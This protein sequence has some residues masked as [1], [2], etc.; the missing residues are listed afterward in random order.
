MPRLRNNTST[1]VG[2]AVDIVL[3]PPQGQL[4]AV[5]SNQKRGKKAGA[6]SRSAPP[7]VPSAPAA[8]PARHAFAVPVPDNQAALLAQGKQTLTRWER[9]APAGEG[10]ARQ[11]AA[12][13]I[14]HAFQREQKTLAL[15]NL[16]L[17][18]LPDCLDKL[19]CIE[20]LNL[21]NNVLSV[22][23]AL[24]EEL[25]R[26]F[27]NRNRLRHFP[28]KLPPGL[29]ELWLSRNGMAQL[30]KD[31]P[32]TIATLSIEENP[33]TTLPSLP[34]GLKRL[35]ARTTHLAALPP[36]P[37][38]LI[39]LDAGDTRLAQLP[40]RLPDGLLKIAVDENNLAELPV[41]PRS[42]QKLQVSGNLLQVLP[43][44]PRG[45][46]ELSAGRN[47]LIQLPTL[48]RSLQLLK[49][50]T[51]LL[52]SLPTL[53]PVV[54]AIVAHNNLIE[55]VPALPSLLRELDL[56]FNPLR[57]IPE[58]IVERLNVGVNCIAALR[59]WKTFGSARLSLPMLPNRW[60][61]RAA[62]EGS[63]TFAETDKNAAAFNIFQAR[64]I[65]TAEYKN[66]TTRP[67]LATRM[68]RLVA[69]M[70]AS[71]LLR[72]TC[73]NIADA[74]ITTCGD[75]VALGLNDMEVAEINHNAETGKYDNHALH[76]MGTNLY[77]LHLINQ[78]AV[79]RIADLRSAGI[80]VDEIEIRL[81]YQTALKKSLDL[82]G[83]TDDMLYRACADL[84]PQ[85]IDAA[86][87]KVRTLLDS[88]ASIEYLAQWPPWRQ[89]MQRNHPA[90]YAVL[91]NES[92][93][94][95]E[96]L[97]DKPVHLS[98]HQWLLAL[99]QHSKHESAQMHAL[100][101]RLTKGFLPRSDSK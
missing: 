3:A 92:Q 28:S 69:S 2:F 25:K 38:G 20:S 33:I 49:I 51:N 31:L 59:E 37:E 44:L 58:S 7:R 67:A 61:N 42:L 90:A 82:P 53:P 88:G 77:K 24:P 60:E 46:A 13:R 100:T 14:L 78:I 11:E 54:T 12:A 72:S 84:S 6:A 36:L 101:M 74:A 47:Q 9:S 29:A 50:E 94:S 87:K 26:L 79:A 8:D 41:L 17:T 89:A 96:A 23:P 64:L 19:H 34:A 68:D 18:S 56:R 16:G 66:A 63:W 1:P 40:D 52:T 10:Y 75:R 85:D 70:R 62:R 86:E 32:D 30:P 91:S 97:S 27:A 81:A 35:F 4:A 99:A 21:D 71:P 15:E 57:Q 48:P 73:F 43:A 55:T 95:G 5:A 93:A 22:L 76:A 80:R 45:L 83:V 98:E 39:E 65:Q